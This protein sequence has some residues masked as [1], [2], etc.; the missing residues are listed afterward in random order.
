[1]FFFPNKK[2]IEHILVEKGFT[3]LIWNNFWNV[4]A[5]GLNPNFPQ[6]CDICFQEDSNPGG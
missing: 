4:L 2:N 1:M 3:R 6:G 5:F